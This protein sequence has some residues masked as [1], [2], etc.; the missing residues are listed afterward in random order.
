MTNA[1]VDRIFELGRLSGIAIAP[2][3][4]Q[5]VSDRFDALLSELDRLAALDLS[6]IEPIAVFPDSSGDAG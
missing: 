6:D 3:E 5:E 1:K 4:A 2:A